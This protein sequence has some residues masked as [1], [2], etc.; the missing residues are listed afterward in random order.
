[1][2]RLVL[3]FSCPGQ[4]LPPFPPPTNSKE[5]STGLPPFISVREAFHG[6]PSGDKLHNVEQMILRAHGRTS[7]TIDD[8]FPYTVIAS[9]DN[10]AVHPDGR[11]FT[12]HE[13]A[14]LQ[15]FPDHHV[16]VEPPS[17]VSLVQQIGNT[18]P[19][20]V[21]KHLFS[22][23]HRW[24]KAHDRAEAKGQP[25][26]PRP[27]S[28][29]TMSSMKVAGHLYDERS[30]PHSKKEEHEELTLQLLRDLVQRRTKL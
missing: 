1:M 17:R 9:N 29:Q 18:V 22:H 3:I 4:V 27:D 10:G 20:S 6:I 5:S 25:K 21:T 26:Q 28:G 23:L 30:R 19:P 11:A 12:F 2:L 7:Y 13:L 8:T 24:L 16:F 14:R 15:G